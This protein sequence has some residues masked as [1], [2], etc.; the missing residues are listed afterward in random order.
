MRLTLTIRSILLAFRVKT[1]L[2]RLLNSNSHGNGHTDHGVV[3][4]AH[5]AHH[6]TGCG[7][8]RTGFCLMPY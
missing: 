1:L 4:C 5:E 6:L 7:F 2:Q 3:T 8:L